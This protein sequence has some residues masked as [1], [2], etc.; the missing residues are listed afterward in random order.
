MLKS[1]L[2]VA[3][4]SILAFSA[5]AK[6]KACDV[7][8]HVKG[9]G[10]QAGVGF[11]ELK[12]KGTITCVE[13]GTITQIPIL[14][15]LGGSVIA[16]REAGGILFMQGAATGMGYVDS[17]IELLGKYSTLQAAGAAGIG[18]GYSSGLRAASGTLVGTFSV[19]L[20]EGVG[21]MSGYATVE[22]SPDPKKPMTIE[23]L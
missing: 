23:K 15:K 21:R 7:T 5:Q 18:V 16:A 9:G 12:G 1:L 14:V 10:I 6:A 22:F 3:V 20:V 4:L 11:F 17:P 2:S 19:N 8:Y 13:K